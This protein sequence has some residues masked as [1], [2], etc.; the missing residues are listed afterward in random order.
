MSLQNNN[1]KEFE[2]HL[3]SE[4]LKY[5]SIEQVFSV[6]KYSLPI[7]FATYHRLLNKYKIIKSAGPNSKLSESLNFLGQLANYKLPL[8][9]AY[10]KYAPSSVQISTNTLHRILHY[11]RLK[12]TRR[13]GAAL[14]VSRESDKNKYLIANDLSLHNP[15]L[16][17]SGDYSLPMT[18]S[19]ENESI[20]DSITRVMQ[21]EM[22]TKET[23][24]G[25]FPKELVPDDINPIMY[26]NIADIKV[27]VYRLV[28][29]DSF[30]NFTSHKLTNFQFA[31][32]KEIQKLNLRPGVGDIVKK[33]E[34]IRFNPQN[35]E[36]IDFDSSLNA[37]LYAWCSK[38]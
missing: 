20:S 16:G 17:K 22:F 27:S 12:I 15:E 3:I 24:M 25:L 19:R 21:Q 4:Y 37:K 7:S 11:T 36:I 5:G 34:E 10:H 2:S 14:L 6:H 18:H 29:P 1:E 13:T 23:T 31:T 26:I 32:N 35:S 8:E 30:E 9:R 38:I 33:Y 28:I